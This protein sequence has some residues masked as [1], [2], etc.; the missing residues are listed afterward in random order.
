MAEGDE[1]LSNTEEPGAAHVLG[2]NRETSVKH[3]EGIRAHSSSKVSWLIAQLK[4]LYTNACSM[5][6][7]QQ[8]LEATVQLESC[9]LTD[10][11]ETG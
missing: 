1:V 3:Y 2:T 5:G 6:N 11:T 10:I 9:D 7:K 8:E 4:C